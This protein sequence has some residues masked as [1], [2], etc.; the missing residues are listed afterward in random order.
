MR[1]LLSVLAFLVGLVL[2]ALLW[3][4]MGLEEEAPSSPAMGLVESSAPTAPTAP[5]AMSQPDAPA[6][7]DEPGQLP[8][9]SIA[10]APVAVPPSTAATPSI[11][12]LR[13][14][15]L[16]KEDRSPIQGKRL[17]LAAP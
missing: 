12:L 11:T 9:R 5:T 16:A 4:A 13:V 17:M 15:L 3:R 8:T 7:A 1:T 2:C 10:P 6:A 14:Q